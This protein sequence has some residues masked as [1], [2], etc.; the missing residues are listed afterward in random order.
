[1]PVLFF[2]TSAA[3]VG[4][5]PLQG[6]SKKVLQ[7]AAAAAGGSQ[8]PPPPASSAAAVAGGSRVTAAAVGGGGGG[9]SMAGAALGRSLSQPRRKTGVRGVLQRIK[10]SLHG[11]H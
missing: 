8:D 5:L 11:A 3:A 1:M 4:L 10:G 9:G 2:R 7:K 6:N